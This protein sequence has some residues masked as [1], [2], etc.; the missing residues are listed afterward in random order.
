VVPVEEEVLPTDKG[1]EMK[2]EI[3]ELLE[4]SV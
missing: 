2:N 3:E 4:K 1:K